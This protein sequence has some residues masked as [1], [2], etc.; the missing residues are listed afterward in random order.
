MGSGQSTIRRSLN[1]LLIK[2]DCTVQIWV[3]NQHSFWMTVRAGFVNV[4]V[5]VCEVETENERLRVF[6]L[7]HT[8]GICTSV[9]I[10]QWLPPS[11]L[12]H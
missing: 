6:L 11:V 5:Q 2:D 9:P 4:F 7:S 12:T 3:M 10:H 1:F 8:V